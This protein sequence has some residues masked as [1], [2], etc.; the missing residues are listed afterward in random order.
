MCGDPRGQTRALPDLAPRL[1][2]SPLKKPGDI[3]RRVVSR[4]L[5]AACI[6]LDTE[7]L[8]LRRSAVACRSLHGKIEA[9]SALPERGA[10]AALS[11]SAKR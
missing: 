7:P 10:G 4:V 3:A 1:S 8:S 6:M 2:Q 9:G 5:H 11:V